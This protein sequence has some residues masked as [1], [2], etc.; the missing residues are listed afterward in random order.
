MKKAFGVLEN[1]ENQLKRSFDL[2]RTQNSAKSLYNEVINIYAP[3]PTD[4]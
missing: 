2:I 4:D 3:L 1:D